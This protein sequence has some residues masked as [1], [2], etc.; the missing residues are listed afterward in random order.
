VGPKLP[1]TTDTSLDIGP[2]SRNEGAERSP[3][4]S[5]Y[6]ILVARELTGL[7]QRRLAKAI[8]TSQ[9]ALARLE[10]GGRMPSMRTLLR[11]TEAAGFDLVIGLARSERLDPDPPALERMGFDLVGTLH[12]NADDGLADFLVIREPHVWAGPP[13]L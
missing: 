12:P 7:S 1:E 5:G 9:P 13:T 3:L 10:T 6:V 11:I 4:G 8:H 2:L